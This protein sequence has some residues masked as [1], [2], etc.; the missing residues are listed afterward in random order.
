MDVKV[1]RK[2]NGCFRKNKGSQKSEG[3][4]G[5]FTTENLSIMPQM[6]HKFSGAKTACQCQTD[7]TKKFVD[8]NIVV[9]S[10]ITHFALRNC[11][12]MFIH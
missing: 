9:R 2:G 3:G 4:F 7:E 5:V 6:P 11:V 1:E 10:I 8:P 12:R